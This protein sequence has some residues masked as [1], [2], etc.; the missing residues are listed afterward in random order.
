MSGVFQFFSFFSVVLG[1]LVLGIILRNRQQVKIR[2][3]WLLILTIVSVIFWITSTYLQETYFQYYQTND[4]NLMVPFTILAFTSNVGILT[5]IIFLTMFV[6]LLISPTI[7]IIWTGFL[8]T[9]DIVVFTLY[10]S[11]FY[12]APTRNVSLFNQIALL[13]NFVNLLFLGLAIYVLMRDLRFLRENLKGRNK[14]LDTQVRFLTFSI[15]MGII[16]IIPILIIARFIDR[17]LISVAFITLIISLVALVYTYVIDP[18]IVFVLPER[19][20]KVIVVGHDG[21]LRH[22]K[23]FVKPNDNLPPSLISGALSAIFTVM[24][25]FYNSEVYPNT[26]KFQDN[27]IL[28]EWSDTFF[29]AAFVKRESTLLRSSLKNTVT[30]IIK[31]YAR[32][33]EILVK[34]YQGLDLSDIFNETFYFVYA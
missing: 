27:L 4:P 5:G 15:L 3:N 23:N 19:I 13:T 1:I 29:V 22:E 7:D 12:V 9:L 8:V 11:L 2:M 10:I 33:P 16:P 21:V 32:T 20:E 30:E 24:S 14:T 26:I 6:Q 31:K 17:N 18:R 28:L 25:D 34:S